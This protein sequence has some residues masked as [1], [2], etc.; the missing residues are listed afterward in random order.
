M[1]ASSSP[2]PTR[3]ARSPRI[4]GAP[5]SRGCRPSRSAAAA[6]RRRA[7]SGFGDVTSADGDAR[8]LVRLIAARGAGTHAPLLYLAGEDRAVDVAAELAASTACRCAPSWSIAPS[9]P[10]PFHRPSRRRSPAARSPACC[11]SPAAA[12]RPISRCAE[13]AGIGAAALAP[14]H[15]CLSPQVAEPLAAAGAPDIRVASRPDEAALLDL[16]PSDQAR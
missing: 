1:R 6:P 8:D 3:P 16:V 10:R 12:P 7:P 4:R 11:T 13:A 5:S 2:A 15:Y 9:R 14:T